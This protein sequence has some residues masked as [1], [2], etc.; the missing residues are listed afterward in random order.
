LVLVVLVA[1][2]VLVEPLLVLQMELEE[3]QVQMA[4]QQFFQTFLQVVEV[5][6]A[7]ALL[8]VLL[9][10]IMEL[11]DKPHLVVMLEPLVVQVE[12]AV[13]LQGLVAVDLLL[14]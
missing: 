3:H 13:V 12:V 11:V 2:Q 1:L 14:D 5:A 10:Q 6:V 8:V 7:L 4:Q 9:L